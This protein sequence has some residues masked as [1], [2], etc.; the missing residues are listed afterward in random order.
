MNHSNEHPS[1]SDTQQPKYYGIFSGIGKFTRAAVAAAALV[2]CDNKTPPPPVAPVVEKAVIFPK[3]KVNTPI[4]QKFLQ[5]FCDPQDRIITPFG[6][7]NE[8]SVRELEGGKIFYQTSD[9]SCWTT[10]VT[11]IDGAQ[12]YDEPIEW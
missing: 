8:D 10:D 3:G 7:I 5:N 11:I 12:H 4:T 2:G 1:E 9:E 6:T